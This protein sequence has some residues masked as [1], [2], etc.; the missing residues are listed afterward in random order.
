MKNIGN[1]L[2]G[3]LTSLG[4]SVSLPGT[5]Q[6]TAEIVPPNIIDSVEALVSIA[7]G[8]LSALLVAWVKRKWNKKDLNKS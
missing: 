8:L 6:S 1:F 5:A 4:V 3:S 2:I 7:S